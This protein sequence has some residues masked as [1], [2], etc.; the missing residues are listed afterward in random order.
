MHIRSFY[1]KIHVSDLEHQI[2]ILE[3]SLDNYC[4]TEVSIHAKTR[5]GVLG[6]AGNVERRALGGLV[7]TESPRR[8]EKLV[9]SFCHS[10]YWLTSG[11]KYL[12]VVRSVDS[13]LLSND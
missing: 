12:H 6:G 1:C 2:V 8:I 4:I 9:K 5:T 7:C 11:L 10:K 13:K 3:V